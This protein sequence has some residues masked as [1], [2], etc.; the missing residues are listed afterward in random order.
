LVTAVAE[1]HPMMAQP[2]GFVGAGEV[3]QRFYVPVLQARSDIRVMAVCSEG[4][5]SAARIAGVLAIPHV[6]RTYRELIDSDDIRSVFVCTPPHAHFEIASYALSK[7][8]NVLIEK[9]AC[10]T[11][12]EFAAL[13][14]LALQSTGILDVTFNNAAREDNRWLAEE[15]R[16]GKIGRL[17]LVELEWLR[18]KPRPEK[19]WMSMPRTSG[20]GGVLADLGSHLIRIGLSLM[21]PARRYLAY[22]TTGFHADPHNAIEDIVVGSIVAD[23]NVQIVLKIGWGMQM[24]EPARVNIRA[25]GTGG[26][27]SNKDYRGP[28]SDGYSHVMDRFLSHVTN[29][30]RVNLTP[31]DHTMRLVHAL[32]RSSQTGS[33]ITVETGAVMP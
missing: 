5:E 21:P 33:P 22:C 1:G 10:S 15:V 13:Q 8:K 20:G 6:A 26:S 11:Y 29:A 28:L 2:V 17:E 23:G 3:F 27:V 12:E 16:R 18:T 7:G 19:A 25:F 24:P 31:A 14:R 30:T 9:P 4:G 32:Y